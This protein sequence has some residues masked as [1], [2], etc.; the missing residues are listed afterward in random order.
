MNLHKHEDGCGCRH[1]PGEACSRRPRLSPEHEARFEDVDR[2]SA[3]V[4]TAMEELSDFA[5]RIADDMLGGDVKVA[6]EDNSTLVNRVG[7]ALDTTQGML[8]T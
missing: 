5:F 7:R 1:M 4:Y 2:R 3:E 6:V 8:K